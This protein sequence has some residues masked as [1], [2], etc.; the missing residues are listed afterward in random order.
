[1]KVVISIIEVL[2]SIVP[3]LHS[4]VPQFRALF[5][6]NGYYEK[7]YLRFFN[8]FALKADFT[9]DQQSLIDV[10]I[11]MKDALQN[12]INLISFGENGKYKGT[13]SERITAGNILIILQNILAVHGN[14]LVQSNSLEIFDEIGAL[15]L[16]L[17]PN[18]DQ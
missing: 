1:V 8:Q 12:S 4:L 5:S 6:T 15:C 2:P 16:R 14:N 18:V 3:E 7:I 11:A 17:L 10:I 9:R 13:Q